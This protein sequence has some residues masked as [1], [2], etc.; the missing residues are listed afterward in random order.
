[1][2]YLGY[3]RILDFSVLSTR[4]VANAGPISNHYQVPDVSLEK[5]LF[6][7]NYMGRFIVVTR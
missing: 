1:M 6:F 3:S 5:R 4:Y 2:D 7:M